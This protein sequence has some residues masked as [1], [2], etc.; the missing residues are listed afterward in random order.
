MEGSFTQS[1]TSLW[2][3]DLISL[4][5]VCAGGYSA[6]LCQYLQDYCWLI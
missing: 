6:T 2:R 4:Q 1:D 3:N 5:Q